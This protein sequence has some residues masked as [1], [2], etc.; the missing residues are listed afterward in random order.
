MSHPCFV[1]KIIQILNL[2]PSKQNKLTSFYSSRSLLVGSLSGGVHVGCFGLRN[3]PINVKPRGG[4]EA[5][6]RR[7]I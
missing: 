7:G 3:A 5:G 6:E 4:G 2:N 1:P